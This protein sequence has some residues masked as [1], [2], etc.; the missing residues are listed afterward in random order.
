MLDRIQQQ[1][2]DF[3]S[4]ATAAGMEREEAKKLAD[5]LYQLPDEVVTLIQTPGAAD[6]LSTTQQ[7]INRYNTIPR[8]IRTVIETVMP[9]AGVPMSLLRMVGGRADGGLI[10]G[11]ATGGVVGFPSGGLVR[12]PGGPRTDSVLAAVSAGEYVVNAKATQ[13]NLEL[14]EAINSG[15][16]SMAGAS[17]TPRVSG[18]RMIPAPSQGGGGTTIVVNAPNYLGTPQEL[19]RAVRQ[20]V[21]KSYGGDVQR[22]FGRG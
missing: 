1:K 8:H 16:V 14:L 21:S 2:A 20:E 19:F 18:A 22:A 3:V 7:L 13:N 10:P 12:G 5:Q 9:L 11:Y 15:E 6:A 4:A 17:T